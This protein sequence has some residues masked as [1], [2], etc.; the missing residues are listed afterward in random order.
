MELNMEKSGRRPR[1]LPVH[2]ALDGKSADI[3]KNHGPQGSY[4]AACVR[5]GTQ[6][7]PM[8]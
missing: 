7:T 2:H 1:L 8:H 5:F 6:G 4:T 3:R